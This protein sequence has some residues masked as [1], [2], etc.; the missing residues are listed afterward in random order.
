MNNQSRSNSSSEDLFFG[1]TISDRERRYFLRHQRRNLPVSVPADK[2]KN[3]DQ[4]DK[5]NVSI[6]PIQVT[7]T[8][9]YNFDLF[10][11]W[12]AKFLDPT[13]STLSKLLV[14]VSSFK[15]KKKKYNLEPKLFE[16]YRLLLQAKSERCSLKSILDIPNNDNKIVDLITQHTLLT[17][18]NVIDRA[19]GTWSDFAPNLTDDEKCAIHNKRIK[20]NM[21][22]EYI[23]SNLTDSVICKLQNLKD[24]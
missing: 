9:T 7:M 22:R 3:T 18:K 20:S 14:I 16:S 8:T 4:A 1:A 19:N 21:L 17:A 11:P 6:N 2:S 10:T 15:D 24:E 5:I 23:L 13:D 12:D